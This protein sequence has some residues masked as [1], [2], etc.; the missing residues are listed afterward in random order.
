VART[1]QLAEVGTRGD[2]TRWRGDGAS[3]TRCRAAVRSLFV[4]PFA[5]LC[6]GAVAPPVRAAVITLVALLK[7]QSIKLQAR[8]ALAHACRHMRPR[9]SLLGLRAFVFPAP[10][11]CADAGA[12][13]VPLRCAARGGADSRAAGAGHRLLRRTAAAEAAVRGCLVAARRCGRC[14]VVILAAAPP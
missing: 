4:S 9:H 8:H 2:A 12:A 5:F 3:L 1:R 14:G 6:R 7:E 13:A 11:R 10:L